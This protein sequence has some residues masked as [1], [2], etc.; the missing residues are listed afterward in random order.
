MASE[1]GER[2]GEAPPAEGAT[3]APTDKSTDAK[4]WKR[5]IC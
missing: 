4:E 5:W 2:E 3:Q 1:Q